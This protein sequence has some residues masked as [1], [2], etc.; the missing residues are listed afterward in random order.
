MTIFSRSANKLLTSTM[1][2]C[3][4]HSDQSV[5][6]RGGR[7]RFGAQTMARLREVMPVASW[8]RLSSCRCFIRWARVVW[9]GLGSRDTS[10]LRQ[11]TW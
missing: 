9:C 8:L 7:I 3:W 4:P 5:A 10:F 11:D 1:T 6:R 2:A